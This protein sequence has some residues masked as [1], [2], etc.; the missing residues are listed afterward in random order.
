MFLK[1]IRRNSAVL[2]EGVVIIELLRNAVAGVNII[3]TVLLGLVLIYWVT[4]ILGLFD[5]DFFDFESISEWEVISGLFVFL[6]TA[7]LPFMLFFSILTINF[8]VLSMFMYYLP[9]NPEGIINGL[10][11]MGAF[12]LSMILTKYETMPLR[13]FFK[14]AASEVDAD[15]PIVYEFCTL[16]CELTSGRLGQAEIEREG[17]QTVINVMPEKVSDVFKK[18]EVAIVTRKDKEKNVY[19]IIKF[20]GESK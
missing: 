3:P 18:R 14:T 13:G 4:V 5:I 11:L 12:A 20:R 9:I 17:A 16:R 1:L 8:W 19:Y 10:L 2:C 7:E 6:N 15:R